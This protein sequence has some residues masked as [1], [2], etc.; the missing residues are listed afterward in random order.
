MNEVPG[1]RARVGLTGLTM[2]E[3]LR[4]TDGGKD[5]LFFMDNSYNFV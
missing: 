5:V 3:S 4:D 1:A 2:A